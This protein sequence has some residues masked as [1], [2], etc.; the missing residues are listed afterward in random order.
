MHAGGVPA[1][2][3]GHLPRL[4]PRHPGR[5]AAL[6]PA[7][8]RRDRPGRLGALAPRH[9]AA[10]ELLRRQARGQGRARLAARRA[11]RRGL[12]RQGQP[13][14]AARASTRRSSTGSAPACTSTRSRCRRST[15][16]R[17]PRARSPGPPSTRGASCGS[18][19]PTV[20][21]IL[22]ERVASGLMDRYLGRTNIKAQ[23]AAQPIDPADAQGQPVRAAARRPR[24]ARDASTT[25][26][27]AARRSCGWRPTSARSPPPRAR[28]RRSPPAQL[29]RRRAQPQ[30]AVGAELD[31]QAPALDAV[32]AQLEQV[33][34]AVDVVA[35]V[36]LGGD[37]LVATGCGRA[38][39]VEPCQ[40]QRWANSAGGSFSSSVLSPQ[41]SSGVVVAA[42]QR[43]SS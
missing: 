41:P 4:D 31:A 19:C 14:P 24:R 39:T 32:V 7:R 33:V 25:R 6:P 38:N 37:R 17:S 27:T 21:T 22:G 30:V 29:A 15:S 2:H 8:P 18:G 42:V 34:D 26:P 43:A 16:P 23:E 20:Y 35:E 13:R 5:A 9:P 40:S 1:R 12:E 36:E 11:D 3:P 10:V 28:A